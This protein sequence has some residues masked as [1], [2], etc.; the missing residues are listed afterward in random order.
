MF[1]ERYA[2]DFVGVD[3]RLADGVPPLP[4]METRREAA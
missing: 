3:D 2:I 1:G 4:R